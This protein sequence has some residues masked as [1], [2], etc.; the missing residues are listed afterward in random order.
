TATVIA[1]NGSPVSATDLAVVTGKQQ[2]IHIVKAVNAVDPAHPDYFEDANTA[3]G[4]YLING[5]TVTFTFAVFT[6][7]F[8]P[9]KSV[10]VTDTPAMPIAPVLN[11]TTGKNVGDA[12]SNDLL[13]QGEIWLFKAT[14]TVAQGLHTDVGS[15]SGIDTV[16]NATLTA[17]DPA[18]YTGTPPGL[19][20]VK[21]I[22]A[23]DPTS[24]T[25]T[26]DA[27][28]PTHP[29]LLA[30]GSN[31]VWTYKVTN[32]TNQDLTGVKVVDDNG[33]PNNPNDDIVLITPTSGDNN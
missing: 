28:D 25:A 19:P 21:A 27:N 24:P 17:T 15:V 18:N 10:V 1:T 30:A 7:G 2:G 23:V 29:F 16:S 9:V 11:T 12:N 32:L 22:N 20:I 6:D 14:G 26:E 31:V 5:T 13:D 3:P 4:V 8:A 33:T